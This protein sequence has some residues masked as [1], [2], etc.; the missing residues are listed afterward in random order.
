MEKDRIF[1]GENGLTETSANFLSNLAKEAYKTIDE[2]LDGIKLTTTDVG[3]LS[4][5]ETKRMRNG[6]TKE[7]LDT[8]LKRLNEIAKYKSL[9]AWLREAIK[10]KSRVVLEATNL[11]DEEVAKALGIEIPV[12]PK[13]QAQMTVDEYLAK[14]RVKE[15]N[16]LLHL[17]TL[18]AVI[19][20]YIHPDGAFAKERAELQKAISNPIRLDGNGRDTVMYKLTPSVNPE[21]VEKTFFSLQA[22]YREYQ[23]QLNSLKHEME[24]A[25]QKDTQ[26]KL[27]DYKAKLSAYNARKAEVQAAI[28]AYR[29]AKVDEC[30][31]LKIII[32]DSLRD[33]YES[34]SRMGK[35]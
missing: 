9:I 4:S 21:D 11:S 15:R 14:L 8:I 2:Q 20:S 25:I 27:F 18:C 29:K 19:G 3:L 1:L 32:P 23:A 31:A 35:K 10:A 16:Q 26:A 17:D 6:N 28:Q 24:I 7:D 12:E 5:N 33:V 22:K 34:V 30:M 13:M